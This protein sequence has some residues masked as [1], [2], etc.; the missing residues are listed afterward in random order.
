MSPDFHPRLLQSDPTSGYGC[1]EA[2]DEAPSCAGYGGKITGAINR[3]KRN[4]YSTYVNEGLPPGP[5]AN[6][7]DRSVLAVLAPASSNYFYFV[8]SGGGRHTF[9]ET[10]ADH[11]KAIKK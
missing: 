11:N 5:I 9:S 2:P 3:D 7:G 8:A 4:R 1:L 6:P 10:L